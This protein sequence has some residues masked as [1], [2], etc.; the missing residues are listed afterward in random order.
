MLPSLPE[1]SAL[2]AAADPATF[3]IASCERAK[4]W[5]ASCLEGNHIEAIVETKAQAEAIRVYT[6][7]KQLG[8]DA[9]LS[10]TEIVRRAERCIGLAIR[11]GQ[12]EGRI[13][14]AGDTG[15]IAMNSYTRVR[16]G[17]RETCQVRQQAGRGTTKV[18]AGQYFDHANERVDI[19][20]MTD[21]VSDD[22]FE[23]ALAAAKEEKNL[24]RANVVR[25]V[26]GVA[27]NGPTKA[28][29]R[30]TPTRAADEQIASAID[31]LEFHAQHIAKLVAD[32][33]D[34][35]DW[36]KRLRAVRTQLTRA[37]GQMEG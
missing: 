36:P 10:A 4:A 29:L 8:A 30:R 1:P 15:P 6:M 22:Q 31:S 35:R 12:E 2:D 34:Y 11:K 18:S 13:G 19:Y 28:I 3:V 16:R 37:I 23:G 33:K 7:Q 32:V 26:K 17:V 9:Q 24:S 14:K 25:K 21:G 5:L 27:H 20:D